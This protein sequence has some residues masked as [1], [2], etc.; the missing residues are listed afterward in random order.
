MN[1]LAYLDYA[2]TAAVRPRAV[3]DAVAA[4]LHDTG[5]TPGRGGH[6]LAIEAGRIALRC[7]QKIARLLNIPGDTGRIAF[8]ANATHALNT[9]IA[10]TVD[11][12]DRLVVTA[13][14]HNAVL[15]PAAALRDVT[16]VLVPGDAGGALDESALARALDGAR[17]LTINAAS[18]VLGTS[19]DVRRLARMARDAGV[20]TLVDVA[21]TA[22]HLPLD[23]AA[24]D[25]DMIAFT[26]HKGMLGPQGIGGLWVRDG[27]AVRP[28]LRGGTGGDSMLR[29]MPDAWPDHL[30]A[31][32]LNAPGI[33]GL[34]AGLDEVLRQGVE[35][36]HARTSALKQRLWDALSAVDGVSVLSPR[37]P[38]GA[39]I[40]TLTAAGIDPA[41][42]AA[43]LDREH[44]VLARPGL[45]CAPEVHRLLGTERTGALRLS[46]G[47]ASTGQDVERAVAGVAAVVHGPRT[48]L[49][50]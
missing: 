27:V 37:A 40:V 13:F 24:W 29:D 48:A 28:L 43:R 31:G 36:I 15:R 14:D 18:N 10:G 49:S 17:L 47:W 39:P 2:A 19:L 21:Q 3:G 4:Y 38:E 25:V 35:R 5:A 50:S 45:H 42:L 11:P 41:A 30:E 7:R 6:R 46:L 33:A 44:G 1:D 26:G 16:L 34:D 23:A 20:L 22:G 12:G 32:S 8:M 9:A